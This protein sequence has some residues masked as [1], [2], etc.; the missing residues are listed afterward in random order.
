M[1]HF[2]S[3]AVLQLILEFNVY[4]WKNSKCKND[5]LR[6]LSTD[7]Q[8][9]QYLVGGAEV[10]RLSKNCGIKESLQRGLSKTALLRVC[11]L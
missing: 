10:S 3:N 1:H 9:T 6:K 11:G 7:T 4:P 5:M 8:D 2:V